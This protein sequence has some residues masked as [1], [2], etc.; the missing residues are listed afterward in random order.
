[1]N[2]MAD[3]NVSTVHSIITLQHL[4]MLHIYV[5]SVMLVSHLIYMYIYVVGKV[6][7]W[8]YYLI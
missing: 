4:L 2:K 8:G 3:L 6:L 7:Y 5:K 1:M